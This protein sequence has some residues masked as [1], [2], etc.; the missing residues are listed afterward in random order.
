[1][2]LDARD[3]D[4]GSLCVPHVLLAVEVHQQRLLVGHTAREEAPGGAGVGGR[5]E[6]VAQQELRAHGPVE[7]AEV[8]GV[9]Q[10]AAERGKGRK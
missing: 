10:I 1:M 8:R 6:R 7:P 5:A 3:P 2:P 4:D 9:P